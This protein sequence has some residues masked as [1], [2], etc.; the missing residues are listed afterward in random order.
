MTDSNRRFRFNYHAIN[1]VMARV[2]CYMGKAEEAITCA[3][4]V[5]DHCG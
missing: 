4:D 5:I 3:Q 2:Y 1:A